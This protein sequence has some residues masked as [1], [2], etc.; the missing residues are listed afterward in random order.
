MEAEQRSQ[1]ELTSSQRS[2]VDVWE[3]HVG[4]EFA[5][6]DPATALETMVPDAY[7]NHVPVLTGGTGRAQLTEFAHACRYGGPAYFPHD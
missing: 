7:V 6:K 4:S 5:T 1:N 3:R 2:M